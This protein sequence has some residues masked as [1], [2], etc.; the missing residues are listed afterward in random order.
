MSSQSRS[1]EEAVV[2]YRRRNHGREP[3]L[4]FDAWW[5]FAQTNKVMLPDEYDPI[6]EGL[7]PFF[8]MSSS[9]VTQRVNEAESVKETYT[10]IVKEGGKVVLQWND[11]YSRD[12][13]W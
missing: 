13:W 7:A 11:D 12:V 9:E 4:G 1:L 3:P 5:Q 8:G 2:E 6:M 10:L